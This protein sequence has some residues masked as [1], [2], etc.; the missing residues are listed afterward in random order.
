[1]FNVKR[2]DFHWIDEDVMRCENTVI[3]RVDVG[4]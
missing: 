4:T 1:M 3:C 2:I